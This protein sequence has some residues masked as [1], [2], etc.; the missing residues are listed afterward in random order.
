M[1]NEELKNFTAGL[2]GPTRWQQHHLRPRSL[3]LVVGHETFNLIANFVSILAIFQNLS[4]VHLT[5][6]FIVLYGC[7]VHQILD[8]AG[9]SELLHFSSWVFDDNR[10]S[11]TKGRPI[12]RV[13]GP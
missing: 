6:A 2:G 1:E 10:G 9:L 3:Q 11:G 7:W 4:D 13:R 5:C 12:D 8:P